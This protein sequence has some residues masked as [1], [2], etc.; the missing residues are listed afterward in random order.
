M[1]HRLEGSL[2]SLENFQPLPSVIELLFTRIVLW[3]VVGMVQEIKQG[4]L[5]AQ[6][7]AVILQNIKKLM[8]NPNDEKLA[9]YKVSGSQW[10]GPAA[11]RH[12]SRSDGRH[13][14]KQGPFC[15]QVKD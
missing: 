2:I 1:R 9:V 3:S 5:A 13:A 8:K 14:E 6:H 7:A 4:Y 10:C 15:W 11:L 12:H